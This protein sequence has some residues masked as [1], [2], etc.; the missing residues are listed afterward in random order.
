[1]GGVD[2]V[3]TLAHGRD[4]GLAQRAAQRVQLAI[5]V[6]LGD[7][8]EINESDAPH[9]ASRQRFDAP[10]AHATDAGNHDVATAQTLG[11][12]GTIKAFE[13]AETSFGIQSTG[14]SH[15][16]SILAALQ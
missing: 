13:P 15:R 9:P 12:A 11:G 6:G 4:L 10:R 1:T 16:D 5:D 7:M 14:I 2:V 8:V 3:D